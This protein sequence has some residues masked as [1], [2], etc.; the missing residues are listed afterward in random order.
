MNII[1]FLPETPFFLSLAVLTCTALSYFTRLCNGGIMLK[2]DTAIKILS[3][4]IFSI[5][6]ELVFSLACR[7]KQ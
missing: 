1:T 4:A 5:E 3:Y 6:F 2:E 7:C